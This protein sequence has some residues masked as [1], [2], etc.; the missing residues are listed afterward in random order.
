M[1][2]EANTTRS[3]R[4]SI[5]KSQANCFGHVM[6]KEKQEHLLTTEMIEGK[7]SWGKQREKMLDGLTKWL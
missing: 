1:I 3:L 2:R 6:K 5:R 4:S 7:R